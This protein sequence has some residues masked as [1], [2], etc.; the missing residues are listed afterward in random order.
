MKLKIFAMVIIVSLIF[1]GAG[2]P[3]PTKEHRINAGYDEN[4]STGGVD[5]HKFIEYFYPSD[6]FC[7]MMTFYPPDDV[8]GTPRSRVTVSPGDLYTVDL[9]ITNINPGDFHPNFYVRAILIDGPWTPLER[10]AGNT[11]D[12]MEKLKRY[13]EWLNSTVPLTTNEYYLKSN[14]LHFAANSTSM[15]ERIT[16]A[17]YNWDKNW[18]LVVLVRPSNGSMWI[19]AES[20]AI[21]VLRHTGINDFLHY[22]YLITVSALLVLVNVVVRLRIN[23]LRRIRM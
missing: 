19:P 23:V 1:M 8:N 3:A 20:L 4:K 13:N 6:R 12:L 2:T 22:I 21:K 10:P 14:V 18:G 7:I 5:Y 16:F 15:S 17:I 11:F 9:E